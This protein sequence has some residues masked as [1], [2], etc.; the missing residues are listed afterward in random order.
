[1]KKA[2]SAMALGCAAAL[3]LSACGAAP[4]QGANS[5]NGAAGDFLACM[6]S[7]EGG[8][9]DQSFNQ[10]GREGLEKAEA[11]LGVSIKTLES[12]SAADYTTNIDS[13]IQQDCD[14]IFGV[15]FN[16]AADLTTAAQANPDVEFALIDASFA[17]TSGTTVEVANGKPL[18]FNTAESAYLAGYAAAAMSKSG[19]VATYGGMAI[20]TVQIFMEGFAKGVAKYNEDTGKS[21]KLL[22][23][24]S[25]NPEGGSF[26]GNFSDT[27]KGQALTN[28]FI[29]QGADVIM[30]VAG[31]VGLGTLS[32][33]KE[34]S[35]EE[36][37]VW[38]DS[39]GFESTDG[40]EIILTSVVK[41][42]GQSVYDT[43]KEASGGSYSAKP[44]IGTLDNSGVALA[45]FHD[46]DSKVPADVKAKIEELRKQIVDGTI[47]VSTPYDP[48]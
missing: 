36:L 2:H 37:V 42:I 47:D 44:Y 11:D 30:P 10:S 20:P 29:S 33:V 13:L 22:G 35:G 34:S 8:F 32:T 21:V 46:Q 48:S 26:V 3:A 5:G 45:P 24:D 14:I 4:E 16:L 38:V 23:W 1:M 18:L 31:P 9:D 39:D 43:V 7:D 6:V 28:Q 41:E 15:G 12:E 19:T 17:D 27:A 40:G 25:S